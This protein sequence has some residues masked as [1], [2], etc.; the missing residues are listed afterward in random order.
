MLLWAL[1]SELTSLFEYARHGYPWRRCSHPAVTS[2]ALRRI[3][4]ASDIGVLAVRVDV[5]VLE[6]GLGDAVP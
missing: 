4:S 3:R 6:V 1:Y 5:A 2:P